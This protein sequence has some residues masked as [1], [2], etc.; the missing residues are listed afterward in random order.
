MKHPTV[1][2]RF[3]TQDGC[4]RAHRAK[5]LCSTHYN[6][7]VPDRHKAQTY[8]CV[9][10]GTQVSKVPAGGR[11]VVCSDRCRW[12][13]NPMSVLSLPLPRDRGA[14]A[15]YGTELVLYVAPPEVPP[16]PRAWVAGRCARCG[17]PYVARNHSGQSRYCSRRCAA[18]MRASRRRA[19]E[20]DAYVADVSPHAIYERDGWM[21][22]LCGD[23]VMRDERVPHPL[24]PTLDHVVA[25]ANGG[26]HEPSNVQLA[27]FLCNCTKG[28]RS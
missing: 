5:G 16:R 26:T 9:V 19:R 25:L 13:V 8:A 18:G 4:D 3:C 15:G 22:M 28:H 14:H 6:Q 12:W 2:T 7:R 23:P 1:L 20:H 11:Q 24:A 27:H 10:C 17:D 21:C